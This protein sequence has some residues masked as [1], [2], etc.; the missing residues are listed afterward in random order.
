MINRSTFE[1]LEE[2][3]SNH[4]AEWLDDN[5][6]RLDCARRDLIEF[7]LALANSTGSIDKRVDEAN[8]DPANV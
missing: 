5:R 1:F 6:A 7:T 4:G 3:S 8:R 2:A